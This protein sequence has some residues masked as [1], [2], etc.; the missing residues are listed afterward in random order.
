[1]RRPPAEEPAPTAEA[2]PLQALHEVALAGRSGDVAT[3]SR[4][5]V[6]RASEL[7]GID[8]AVIFVWDEAARL[9]L[10]IYETPSTASEGA[11]RRGEG[12]IGI[13]FETCSP[14]LLDDYQSWEH[15][16]AGSTA[17]GMVSA[18]A[19]PLVADENPIGALGLWTYE[20][21]HFTA[22]DVRLVS[23]F[24]AQ[25]APALQSARRADERDSQTQV[26]RT[27]HEVAVAAG[28]VLDDPSGLARLTVDK[29]RDLLGVESASM[30]WWDPQ[31]EVLRPLADNHLEDTNL[32]WELKSG[33]GAAG[34]ALE[35][36]EP[37]V[38]DDYEGWE[39]AIERGVARGQ[40]SLLVVP[41][42][43]QDRPVGTLLVTEHKRQRHFTAEEVELLTLLASQVAP[44][45][46]AARLHKEREAQVFNLQALHEVA[47][48][49]SGVLE[50]TALAEVVADRARRL[51][52]IEAADI[53]WW[54]E[55]AGLLRHLAHAG[56]TEPAPELVYAPG[57]GA[58]GQA[59]ARREPV[60]IEDYAGWEHRLPSSSSV[61]SV[62]AV[63]LLVR[64]RA[65]GVLD[66][67]STNSH[68]S[69]DPS[70]IRLLTLLAAQVAPAIKAAQ[71]V[72]ERQTQ[73]RTFQ[74]LHEVA[75]AASG[76]LDPIALAKL[77]VDRARD[78]L[79]VDSA[80]L[81]WWEPADGQLRL[82]ASNDPHPR[83]Q[84][85]AISDR[86]GILGM[87]L[88]R[89]EPVVVDD[90]QRSRSSLPWAADDGVMTAM[91]VPLMVGQRPVGALA[92]ATYQPHEYDAEQ[93]RL[94]SLFAGQVA[95]ALEAA[96]LAGESAR[97]TEIFK[98]LHDLAVAGGGVL[99]TTTLAQLAV[100]RARSLLGADRSVLK[101]FDPAIGKLR[102]L[103]RSGASDQ[104]EDTSETGVGV[105]GIAFELGQPVNV[106]DYAA[107][108]PAISYVKADG[109]KSAVA[110][111]LL[112]KDKPVGA[113][114]V[115]TKAPRKFEDQD[116]QLLM[117]LAA[118]VAPAL[119]ASRL[120]A[121]LAASERQFRAILDNAPVLIARNDL[122]GH[123]LSLNKTGEELLGYT[124][125][126][127][128]GLPREQIMA[129]DGA[130]LD[131]EEFEELRLGKR[132]R[133]RVQRRYKRKDG[134][135]F[136]GDVTLSLVRDTEGK[137]DFYFAMLEDVTERLE[138]IERLKDSEERKGAILESAIDCI[139]ALDSEGRI[140]EFN[141]AAERTFGY[142]RDQALGKPVVDLLIAPE[143][144]DTIR[145]GLQQFVAT[146]EPGPIGQRVE[147]AGVR[148]DG[149]PIPIELAVS[150]FQQDGRPMFT[151]AMRDLSERERAEAA[152]R[153]SE[154]RFRIVFDRAPSGLARLDLEGNV[155]EANPALHRML[156]YSAGELV[157]SPLGRFIHPD[158]RDD[159]RF[160]NLAHGTA[161][162]LQMEVRYIHKH[163]AAV[164]GNT[165][166]S[167]VRNTDGEPRFI[168]AMV[169]DIT[170]RKVQEAQLE[171]RAL[172]DALTDL[173]NRDLLHDR[174]NQA[175]LAGRRDSTP[176]ALLLMDLDG[177][178]DV[179]DAFGHSAGDILLQQVAV[180]L[181]AELRSS[182]TVARL[183]GDEFAIVLPSV[184]NE[185]AAELTARKLL[186]AL[187][188]RFMIEGEAIEVGGSIGIA[189]FPD[190]GQ[191]ADTLLRRA[192]VAMYVAKRAKSGYSSYAL[193]Q[194]THISSR[195]ALLAELRPAI[196]HGELVLHYQPKV[197]IRS[198]RIVGVE[199]VVRWEH[200]RHGLMMPDQFIPLAEQSGL[201]R[202]LGL[203]VLKSALKQCKA[204]QEAG[205]DLKVAVNLSMRNLHDPQLPETIDEI[206]KRYGVPAELLQVEI[207]E[208]T[209]M[210][211]PE[212]AIKLL[213]SLDTMGVKLSIDD[214]GIGYS[215]LA[216]LRK[217]PAEE[218]KIDKSFVLDMVT[219]ENDAVIVRSTI[220]L[221]HNLGMRVVAEGVEN[222]ET[223]DLLGSLEC[224]LAQGYFMS[225]PQAPEDLTRILRRSNWRF[226]GE[227]AG[228]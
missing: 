152:R 15:A 76:V 116:I 160:Q 19:V 22:D 94:L 102:A 66:V 55:S 103:A 9:L 1:M 203:W 53:T 92:V 140:V 183:G 118:Q 150:V 135:Q 82:L 133:Y 197:E 155:I 74:A 29:A 222:Q 3:V 173:P 212:H 104:A 126:E 124:N 63:P 142:K 213:T 228:S 227:R 143:A 223:W 196:D 117:L 226:A 38:V 93:V 187:E 64:D 199:A 174:L 56:A 17:R 185:A 2:D 166:A 98:A 91:A 180:R 122:E 113:I 200:P 178:K 208:T 216:Y 85:V 120:H 151:V 68:H 47:V 84:V 20:S 129:A 31:D 195:L 164:W 44:A 121:D 169:E 130:G 7:L 168:I 54:D 112:S 41:L 24:A 198:R 177:F 171:H 4:L 136:W 61:Q 40:K 194:D 115:L 220:D 221:G 46:E 88:E 163:G 50:T 75:V 26:F 182:D 144:R 45:I 181:R 59:F 179:N 110:V 145:G 127:A 96:R 87:A 100:D 71:L 131:A 139:I 205:L 83:Q 79:G 204:W 62:A 201:I 170:V 154:G 67:W 165:I 95:P 39:H 190:H 202:R 23:L 161:S 172:H 206:L 35:S 21:R 138:A 77:T 132:D 175:I 147:T 5:A 60:I 209:L 6:E 13:A 51:L 43:V 134:K 34:L 211:D 189:L 192:D 58:V 73:A 16:I 148:A 111:P 119:E 69:F 156:G 78:L 90:Y 105:S 101:W 57:E 28:G 207:T 8:G 162:E 65:V 218:I 52:G 108:E 25:V 159:Q 70:Q 146:G 42:M 188:G 176:V 214:F 106:E 149:S 217:L 210:A 49:A 72:G 153:E 97:Q 48:A 224:D 18:M 11:V 37:V 109:I 30:S 14:V 123:I 158:D 81:R 86:Q 114:S 167:L 107:W 12:A 32:D 186:Q 80:V 99:E 36:R 157:D 215:S 225:I 125:E 193:E 33:E 141:P 27:L 128:Q 10:P 137:P 219:E 184:D 191:D 89:Q